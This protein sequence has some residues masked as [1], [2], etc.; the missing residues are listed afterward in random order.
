M[1]GADRGE[2][3]AVHAGTCKISVNGSQQWFPVKHR[4]RA[5]ETLRAGE[6]FHEDRFQPYTT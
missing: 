3:H 5:G 2:S 1:E 4:K 6:T